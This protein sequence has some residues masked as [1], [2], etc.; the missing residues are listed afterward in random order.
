MRIIPFIIA[1]AISVVALILGVVHYTNGGANLK[2]QEQLQT[3]QQ[4]VQDLN[5]AIDLQNKE[6]QRQRQVIEQGAAVDQKYGPPILRDIGILAVRNNN[7]KLKNLLISN[8]LQSFIPTPEQMK[9]IEEQIKKAQSAQPTN[10][11][12]PAPANQ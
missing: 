9:Q 12:V 3:K 10:G 6:F 5:D 1:T 2:Q 11:A 4:R 7:E 8:K